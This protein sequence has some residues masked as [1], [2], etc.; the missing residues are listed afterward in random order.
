LVKLQR[1]PPEIRISCRLLGVLQH[2]HAAATLTGAH[3][4]YQAGGTAA[5]NDDVEIAPARANAHASA[6]LMIQRPSARPAMAHTT[7]P[8]T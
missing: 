4:A 3:R 6:R 7:E 5:G 2:Q 1:P 8:P